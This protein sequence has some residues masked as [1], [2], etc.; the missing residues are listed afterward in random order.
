MKWI[1]NGM[2][3]KEIRTMFNIEND[4]TPE[5][6]EQIRKE[7]EW[8]EEKYVEGKF[9]LFLLCYQFQIKEGFM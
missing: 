6:L 8:C 5:D 4:P 9:L 3:A 1:I 2:M 7:T